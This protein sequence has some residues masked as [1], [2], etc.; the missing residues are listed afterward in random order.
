MA[1]QIAGHGPGDLALGSV[2]S[3]SRSGMPASW[4]SIRRCATGIAVPSP[5]NRRT[6]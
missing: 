4:G 2:K 1:D 3:L 6:W 5:H